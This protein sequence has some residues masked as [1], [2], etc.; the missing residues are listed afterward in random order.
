MYAKIR[1]ICLYYLLNLQNFFE[2][3]FVMFSPLLAKL[4]YLSTNRLAGLNLNIHVNA[5]E[6]FRLSDFWVTLFILFAG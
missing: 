4:Q 5:R 2:I 3:K 1:Y 6:S